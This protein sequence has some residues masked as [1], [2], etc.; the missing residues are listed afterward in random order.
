VIK[1]FCDFSTIFGEKMPF[2]SKTNDMINILQQSSFVLSKK[3]QLFG[4]NIFKNNE[5]GHR[6]ILQKR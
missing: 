6:T 4:E 5:I 3:R 1:I 2:L